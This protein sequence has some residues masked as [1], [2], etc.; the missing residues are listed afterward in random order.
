LA[1]L[2]KLFYRHERN[3]GDEDAYYLARETDTGSVFILH[4]WSKRQGERFES[5]SSHIE[6]AVFLN[7]Q[8]TAQD[9]LRG[10]IGQLVT[11]VDVAW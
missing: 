8:G 11:D 1:L 10:L 7:H 5:S 3:M 2:S 6:L 4:K 9:N